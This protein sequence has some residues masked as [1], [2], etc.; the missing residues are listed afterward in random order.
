[1][2]SGAQGGNPR[3]CDG[4]WNSAF[5]YCDSLASITIPE[6]VTAIEIGAFANCLSLESS[7]SLTVIGEFAFQGCSYCSS[8]EGITI[9]QSVMAIGDYAFAECKSLQNI[10]IPESLREDGQRAF[11]SELQVIYII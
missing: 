6:S 2:Q 4:Y 10:T 9:P 11:D 5:A 3:V 7:Q 1:M 8:L